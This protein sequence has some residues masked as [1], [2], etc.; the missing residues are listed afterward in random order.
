MIWR[1]KGF[2]L[3]FSNYATHV[4][5]GRETWPWPGGGGRSTSW[6]HPQIGMHSCILS[7]AL[8]NIQSW[9]GISSLDL[10]F[11]SSFVIRLL[12]FRIPV[13]ECAQTLW[14]RAPFWR[15]KDRAP[16]A[17]TKSVSWAQSGE[18]ERRDKMR[19]WQEVKEDDPF[20]ASECEHAQSK[21]TCIAS[22]RKCK[23]P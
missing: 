9:K 21:F 18:E 6:G 7:G 16:Q 2:K 14:I 11:K 15:E 12:L 17:G 5:V 13:R 23:Y 3:I 22:R 20:M 8:K 19:R 1:W 10:F 4:T